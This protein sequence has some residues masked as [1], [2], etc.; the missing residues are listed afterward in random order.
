MNIVPL[1][2]WLRNRTRLSTIRWTL[3]NRFVSFP[4]I[5]T[6]Y[7]FRS[8]SSLYT[9]TKSI[10]S[11]WL[12][13]KYTLSPCLVSLW[14]WLRIRTKPSPILRGCDKALLPNCCD[15]AIHSFHYSFT[16]VET[17]G[18]MWGIV[19]PAQYRRTLSNL[20]F[21]SS[22]SIVHTYVKK[23]RTYVVGRCHVVLEISVVQ[24]LCR[25]FLARSIEF[26]NL[27]VFFFVKCYAI[28]ICFKCILCL[29]CFDCTYVR[30][31]RKYLHMYV[32]WEC[33]VGLEISVVRSFCGLF[34]LYFMECFNLLTFLYK[35][36]R[37]IVRFSSL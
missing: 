31:Q 34:P 14:P 17:C 13:M 33:H 3:R 6:F 15:I 22:V 29:E 10:R 23:A 21:V 8:R 26:L 20:F 1:I 5:E 27:P 24:S 4:S 12:K 32:V 30:M 16:R 35:V 37:S 19:G 36:L 2:T 18:K 28:L 7:H 9:D 25:L 11:K